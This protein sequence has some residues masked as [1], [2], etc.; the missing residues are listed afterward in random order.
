MARR[1][2]TSRSRLERLLD[3]EN[4]AVSLEMLARR[5]CGGAEFEV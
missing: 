5:A 4:H 2:N 1:M 3:P